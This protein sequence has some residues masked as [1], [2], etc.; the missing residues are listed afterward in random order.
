MSAERMQVVDGTRSETFDVP[1]LTALNDGA[2]L[3]D[4]IAQV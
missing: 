3:F 2:A 4:R 1:L